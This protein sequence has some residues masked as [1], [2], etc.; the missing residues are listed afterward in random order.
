MALYFTQIIFYSDQADGNLSSDKSRN[1]LRIF[2][3]LLLWSILGVSLTLGWR[4][5]CPGCVEEI[6]TVNKTGVM[7]GESAADTISD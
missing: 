7:C 6:E 1:C 3:R 5:W 2:L 4:R